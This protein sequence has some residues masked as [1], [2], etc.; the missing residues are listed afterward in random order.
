MVNALSS[1]FPF[2]P[3]FQLIIVIIFG[4]VLFE[5]TS[6]ASLSKD[7]SYKIG[8]IQDNNELFNISNNT[9]HSEESQIIEKDNNIFVVWLDDSSGSRDIFFKKSSDYG[10][11]FNPTID[12]GTKDGGSLDP[13]VALSGN[14]IYVVWENTPASNG[15]IFFTRSS[16]N[17]DSFEKAK[18][19]GNN[20]G[21]N[22]FPQ[23]AAFGNNVYV[24]WH[25]ATKGVLLAKSS[26][27]GDSFEKAK[28]LGN[29]TG[30]NGFPQIAVSGS[31]VYV[32]W[33][34]NFQEKYGQIYFTRSIDNG[35]SFSSPFILHETKH[36]GI[37]SMVFNPG[38]SAD[39]RNNN[40]YL[41]WYSGR[42][43][44]HANVKAL[45][46]DVYFSRS[47]DNGTSFGE[48]T[49]LSNYSGWSIDPQI[50]VSPDNNVYVVWTNNATG[51]EE[52]L[53]KRNVVDNKICDSSYSIN[54]PLSVGTDR[55]I[56]Y[57]TTKAINVA[58]VQATFT[59]AAYDK[60][61]YMFYEMAKLEENKT[62]RSLNTTKYTDLLS[63]QLEKSPKPWSGLLQ[64]EDH[65]KWL[66]PNSNIDILSD[67]DVHFGSRMFSPNGTNLYDV[68]ILE[69]QEYV[70]QQEYDNLKKFVS[71]GGLL[72][73]LNGNVFYGEVNY[74]NNTD[75]INLVKGHGFALNVDTAWKSVKER[76]KAETSEWIGSNYKCCFSWEFVF[77]NDPFGITHIEEQSITNP[78]AKILLDYNATINRP[79]S[80]HFVIATYEL[81]YKKG[82][83]ITLGI[84]TV[85]KLF[86][87]DRFLRFFD[88]LLYQYAL[89]E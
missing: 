2:S 21:F 58:I 83:V 12:L 9:G 54:K 37:G 56:N 48:T 10:C 27:N 74:D 64:I 29:N 32:V 22:G 13:R 46:S 79:D 72:F 71:N 60:S 45:I 80:G 7:S 51:N 6:E 77:L 14:N 84:W 52:I 70:T 88:S 19:L 65:F 87:N 41:V 35:T 68:V 69:H 38:I 76:W 47:I 63:S 85:N 49:N 61:F 24:V 34:N 36:D 30:F 20:T 1:A 82:K 11:T 66:T 8:S 28:N 81:E 44:E 5:N 89:G 39:P 26:D 50:A 59:E 62:N 78:K 55:E 4:F 16:D 17:G 33:T 18:N 73:L 40:V 42:V 25:D 86:E 31:N 23:I 15:A 53:L 43:V 3:I 67:K 75:T 57:N